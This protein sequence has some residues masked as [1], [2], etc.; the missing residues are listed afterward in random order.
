LDFE[1]GDVGGFVD[2]DDFGGTALVAFRIVGEADEDAVGFVDDVVVGNDVAAGIDDEAGAEGLAFLAVIATHIGVLAEEAVEEVLEATLTLALAIALTLAVALALGTLIVVVTV[3][4]VGW[5]RLLLLGE[6]LHVAAAAILLLLFGE[7]FGIDVDDGGA[8]FFGDAGK[9]GRELA[10]RGDF[11]RGGIRAVDLRFLAAHVVRNDR[12]DENAGGKGGENR[13]GRS[14]TVI[15][16]PPKKGFHV[17]RTSWWRR[18]G[19]EASPP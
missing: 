1:D 2:A 5:L 4:A 11:E 8:N 7:D 16:E 9:V 19:A 10:G 18:L 17:N 15:A 12:A 14:Q 6:G 3:V 13:E